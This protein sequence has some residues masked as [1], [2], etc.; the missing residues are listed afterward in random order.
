LSAGTITVTDTSRDA[1]AATLSFESPTDYQVAQGFM[2]SGG[3]TVS[4]SA[5]GATVPAFSGSL[6]GT[7]AP[8][9][10]SP[11]LGVNGFFISASTDLTVTW[12]PAGP[13][14]AT[15]F[16]V[17]TPVAAAPG[18]MVGCVSDDSAG[19][20]TVPASLLAQGLPG[21]LEF[22][23]TVATDVQAGSYRVQLAL[24]S[25]TVSTARMQP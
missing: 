10:L 4:F 11:T 8:T 17:L 16:V 7:T 2:W 21:D 13:S 9:L 14:G 23:R 1:E 20:L 18:M 3:D 19:T 25:A 5:A 15:F 12:T 6:V 24:T 22:G